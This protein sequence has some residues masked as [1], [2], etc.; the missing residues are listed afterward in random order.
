MGVY[1]KII[2]M[3]FSKEEYLNRFKEVQ[4]SMEE[5]GLELLISQDTANINYLTGYDAWSFYYAQCAIIHINHEE[6]IL[7][8]RAQDAGGAYLNSFLK[9]ENI[10]VYE[11]KY[12]HSWPMHPYDKL[13]EFLKK[14]KRDNFKICF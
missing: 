8:I 3:I 13:I 11:E 10:I 7:F 9:N 12:I 5:K 2:E 1:S 6:P 4:K 14:K